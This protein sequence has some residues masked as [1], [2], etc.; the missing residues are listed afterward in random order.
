MEYAIWLNSHDEYIHL[1]Q[2]IIMRKTL[3]AFALVVVFPVNEA[4]AQ[5]TTCMGMGDDMVHCDT[6]GGVSTDCMAMGGGLVTCNSVG[7]GARSV[8]SESSSGGA[9]GLMDFIDALHEKS[10]RKKVGHMLAAGDC[11]G[12]A[13]YAYEKGRLELGA[14]IA[15]SCQSPAVEPTGPTGSVL[16][17]D[18]H[19]AFNE[20]G[21]KQQGLAGTSSAKTSSTS[22]SVKMPRG[23]RCVTCRR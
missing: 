5:S 1:G 15:R 11:R 16:L 7:G 14:A 9:G 19:S 3:L 12:A 21:T 2:G 23:V 10:I 20:S 18:S 4:V 13:N 17:P 6:L 8:Q 22:P